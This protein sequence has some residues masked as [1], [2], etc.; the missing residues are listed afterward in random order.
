MFEQRTISKNIKF[1]GFGVHSGK[2]V[3]VELIPSDVDTG[4]TIMR[5]DINDKDNVIPVHYENVTEVA[6]STKIANKNGI[7]VNT[8]EHCMAAIWAMKISNLIIKIDTEEMPIMDGSAQNFVFLLEAI[9]ITKQKTMRKI[10]K[11]K[12]EVKIE[13]EDGRS[14]SVAPAENFMATF[15]LESNSDIISNGSGYTFNDVKQSFI[16]DISL[17]RTFCKLQ[18]V[19]KIKSLGMAKGGSLNNALVIDGNKVL[20]DGGLRYQNECVRHKILDLIGD[21]SLSEY[22]IAGHF[23]GYNSGHE[24][25]NKLMR[26]IF[27]SSENYDII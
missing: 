23:T 14:I 21:C 6:Y 9:G 3:N 22:Y 2:D 1:S 24:I 27:S 18:D 19:E 25:N 12:Q 5:T 10:A 4:I 8:I 11:I 17:A 15:F 13:Y 26:K 20:N 16:N 7:F